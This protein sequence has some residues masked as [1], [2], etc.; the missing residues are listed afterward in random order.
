MNGKTTTAT[1]AARI[2]TQ[3][4]GRGDG[5]FEEICYDARMGVNE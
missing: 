2:G 5:R 1:L 4:S 3:V